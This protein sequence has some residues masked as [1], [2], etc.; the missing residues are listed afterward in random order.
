MVLKFLKQPRLFI[1][2]LAGLDAPLALAQGDCLILV[3]KNLISTVD[4][5]QFADPASSPGCFQKL[6]LSCEQKDQLLSFAQKPSAASAFPIVE[7]SD[8]YRFY[9]D[10]RPDLYNYFTLKNLEWNGYREAPPPP[11]SEGSRLVQITNFRLGLEAEVQRNLGLIREATLR[12]RYRQAQ[13]WEQF[14]TARYDADLSTRIQSFTLLKDSERQDLQTALRKQIQDGLSLWNRSKVL[15][16]A[17]FLT[18]RFRSLKKS[19]DEARQLK[20]SLQGRFPSDVRRVENWLQEIDTTLQNLPC[21]VDQPAV[22]ISEAEAADWHQRLDQQDSRAEWALA[23][24]RTLA[25]TQTEPG[26]TV[27]GEEPSDQDQKILRAARS[28]M[29]NPSEQAYELLKVGLWPELQARALTT[30]MWEAIERDPSLVK[31]SAGPLLTEQPDLTPSS[32]TL[33]T[34]TQQRVEALRKDIEQMYRELELLT[35]QLAED[36]SPA[37]LQ[38]Y[39][40]L[41]NRL[42]EKTQEKTKLSEGLFL[43][44]DRVSRFLWDLGDHLPAYSIGSQVQLESIQAQG[45]GY[46]WTPLMGLNFNAVF[47][48]IVDLRTDISSMDGY[49]S[50][51]MGPIPRMELL[52]KQSPAQACEAQ[53]NLRLLIRV[54]SVD[55][56]SVKILLKPSA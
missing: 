26:S 30:A 16:Q 42:M 22:C 55:G 21:S 39:D 47:S 45:L 32:C 14:L 6:P 11:V 44:K 54:Q 51:L 12:K 1:F 46:L 8:L 28:F 48:D 31:K 24:L 13:A 19:A 43:R 38:A 25:R 40:D 9:R 35:D 18:A 49:G 52:I 20:T 23:H 33:I 36:D 56:T 4:L 5:C 34:A 2:L 17:S 53:D 15:G 37:A 27:G 41:L 10:R 3:R 29:L 7:R 50:G